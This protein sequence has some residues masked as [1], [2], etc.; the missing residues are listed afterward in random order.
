MPRL[1][2]YI[3]DIII[4]ELSRDVG[5]IVGEEN[6]E[7]ENK[8]EHIVIREQGD[9][10]FN[11]SRNLEDD[12]PISYVEPTGFFICVLCKYKFFL[13]EFMKIFLWDHVFWIILKKKK[14]EVL[15]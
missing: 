4:F 13:F 3:L 11:S 8:K 7:K 9:V 6:I 15:K 14:E 10:Y 2:I 12:C 1:F 5:R